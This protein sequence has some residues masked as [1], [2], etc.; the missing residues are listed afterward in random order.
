VVKACVVRHRSG[1][2]RAEPLAADIAYLERDG[3]TR[4]SEKAHMF[5]ATEDRSDPAPF[6]SRSHDDRHHFPFI[7]RFASAFGSPGNARGK[8]EVAGS[9]LKTCS[10][11]NCKP[12]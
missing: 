1:A 9:M 10:C 11:R 5:G 8:A 2:L 7:E 6:A 4:D 12:P 3:V